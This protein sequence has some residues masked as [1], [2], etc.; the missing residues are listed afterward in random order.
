MRDPRTAVAFEWDDSNESKLA[1]R[2]VTPDEVERMF[3]H[4][5]IFYRGKRRGTARW[6][7]EGQDPVTGKRMRVGVVWKDAK[8]GILR[9]IHVLSLE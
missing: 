9:A 3:E 6:M 8:A 7:I 2:G 5:P 4:S 1:A